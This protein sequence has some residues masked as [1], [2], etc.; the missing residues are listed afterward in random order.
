MLENCPI[1]FCV[2]STIESQD[3]LNWK[4]PQRS[5]SYR[6]TSMDWDATYEIRLL[7][8][9]SNLANALFSPRLQ[10]V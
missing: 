3:G 4:E 7:R 5:S 2:Q 9:I 8:A 6:P 10:E 1:A